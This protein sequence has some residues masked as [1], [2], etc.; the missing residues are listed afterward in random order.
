MKGL[1]LMILATMIFVVSSCATIYKNSNLDRESSTLQTMAI[2]PFNVYIKA[3]K[4]SKNRSMELDVKTQ[5]DEGIRLQNEVYTRFLQQNT[6]LNISIQDVSLT[7]AKIAEAGYT[8]GNLKS[9]SKDKLAE[10]LG[11]DMIL[12]GDV[13]EKK[14]VSTGGAIAIGVATTI[15]TPMGLILPFVIPINE[16]NMD[17]N[18]HKKSESILMWK[19]H[20]TLTG[21]VSSTPEN[22]G[23]LMVKEVVNKFPFVKKKKAIKKN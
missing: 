6:L 11:V 15:V 9:I 7:N 14:P 19:Y 23:N 17:V 22:I 1:K 8:P 20:H 2:V 12:S 18:L 5:L 16:V 21:G 13:F 3:P 4:S 10:L